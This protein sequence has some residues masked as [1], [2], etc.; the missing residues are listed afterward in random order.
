MAGR[1]TARKTAFAHSIE[2]SEAEELLRREKLPSRFKFYFYDKGPQAAKVIEQLRLI[3]KQRRLATAAAKPKAEKLEAQRSAFDL[4]ARARALLKGREIVAADLAEAGGAYDLDQVRTLL[5][6]I[7]RQAVMKKVEDGSLLAVPGPSNRRR[8]P[9]AQF[10]NEGLVPGLRNV[11][12]ALPTRNS[13]AVL[14][15]LITPDPRLGGRKPIHV[16]AAGEV[17]AVV[18]AARSVGVQGS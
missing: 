8:Y 10:S 18:S 13:W 7:S 11:Q 4:G 5:N 14:N 3:R 1:S 12:E 6:G 9:A 16:L 17:E 2:P 15:F